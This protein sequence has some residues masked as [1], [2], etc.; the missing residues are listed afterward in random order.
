MK[1]YF[2][3]LRGGL[4]F[5]TISLF[6]LFSAIC[7]LFIDALWLRAVVFSIFLL[8]DLFSGVKIR[9]L[10]KI[11]AF[12]F[13]VGAFLLFPSGKILFEYG[14]ISI[15]EDAL[16]LGIDNYLRFFG[17]ILISQFY[18]HGRSSFGNLRSRGISSVF[19]YYQR[20]ADA[21]SGKK[22]YSLDN[23]AYQF[24]SVFKLV[25]SDCEIAPS[26]LEPPP[27]K[28]KSSRRF[29]SFFFYIVIAVIMVGLLVLSNISR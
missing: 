20:F 17:L 5:Y 16:I 23:L 18:F 29:F 1:D 2:S 15:T 6:A 14:V 25:A 7:F 12:I 11:I 9:I 4:S 22:F 28:E 27:A 19:I 21:L 3:S 24:A 26:Q 8:L 13:V 10:Q